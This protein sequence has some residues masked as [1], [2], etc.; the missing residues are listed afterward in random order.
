M[1]RLIVSTCVI[2]TY[3]MAVIGTTAR[4]ADAWADLTGRFVLDG[5]APA[6]KKINP[7]KDQAV[8][9][10]MPLY[11]ESLVVDSSGGIANVVIYVSTKKVKVH[12][13]YAAEDSARVK[14]DNKDCRFE[15]HITAMWLTQTLVFTNSDPV[16]HNSNLTP[17]LN[18]AFN[19]LIPTGGEADYKFSKAERVPVKVACNVH[20]WM[21]GYV[22]VR[23]NPYIAISAADGTFTLKNLPAGEMLEFQVWQEKSG[24]VETAKW[25]KGRFEMKVAAGGSD[26]GEI[27]LPLKLFQK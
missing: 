19:Q 15:P 16:G 11:D 17:L 5:A 8:C 26:L 7:D 20:S 18:P 10:K 6:Q 24:Y 13:D 2:M 4:A 1:R 9:G 25:K 23:D 21:S 14:C 3:A 27:K 22:V 12:P